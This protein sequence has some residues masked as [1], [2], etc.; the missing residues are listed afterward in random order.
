MKDSIIIAVCILFTYCQRCAIATAN[1]NIKR[2]NIITWC[3]VSNEEFYKCGNFS[4]AV[5]IDR[6]SFSPKLWLQVECLQAANKEDCMSKLNDE[7]ADITTL[8]AGDVFIG[9]RYFSLLP[10]M[11]ELYDNGRW[12]YYSVAVIKKNTLPD[13]RSL[14][15]LRNKK[16]CFASVGSVASWVIPLET[17]MIEGGLEVM[18]CN[19]HVKSA[20]KYFG[21]SCAVNSLIDKYNPIGDNS[22]KLCELCIGKIPGGRCTSADPYAGYEGA[23]RCLV[24]TGEIAFLKHTTVN[25]MISQTSDFVSVG[26]NDF[27]L[28]CRDGSRRPVT[29]YEKCNWGRVPSDAV[30]VSSVK[31]NNV[32]KIYQDFLLNAV[33]LYSSANVTNTSVNSFSPFTTPASHSQFRSNSSF[34]FFESAPKYGHKHNLFLQDRTK[35]LVSLEENKQTYTAYLGDTL[36]S[37][38]HI[39]HCPI[40]K[41]TLCVTSDSEYE[42]CIKMKIA[43]KSQLLKPEMFCYKARSH[44]HCMQAIK[45]RDADVAVFDAGDVYTAGSLY[46][47]IPFI[48]EVYNLGVPEYYVVAVAKEEDP[49]TEM[50][51][52][53][54]KYTCHPGVHTGGGWIIPMAYLIS[55]GWIR[56]YGCDSVRAAVEYFGKSCAPGA[57][58]SE[59]VSGKGYDNLCH[60]CHGTSYKYC[61]RDANEDYYGFTGA[62]RC[63]VEGG[64]HVAFLKH[65]TVYENTDGKRREWWARNTLS[66]DFQLLCSDGT[67]SALNNYQKCNIG[68]VKANAIVTRGGDLYNERELNAFINLFVYAQQFFGRK[69]DEE[70]SMFM[71]PSPYSD[72]IFQDATQQLRVIESTYRSYDKYL[73]SDFMRAKRIVDCR[74]SGSA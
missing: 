60:L 10:I 12:Y 42:K 44:I 26:L 24:E 59:Y 25:E 65:T 13:V 53:K 11:Q 18:D 58:S 64:G 28:L 16:A 39:R 41:M 69:N 7:Y 43:L 55:N 3:T 9:G 19:N 20:I 70:F 63:L 34:N 22:N 15:D 23:F 46:D 36:N 68:K 30:V 8:E 6:N 62:F 5:Q 57:A 61:Q 35:N 50:T 74:A 47:L 51:Y 73:G 40:E 48:S 1:L 49:S 27:E 2:N 56:K 33:K 21:P 29:E 38:L 14:Y 45:N 31:S 52:L 72:L 67:R 4:E 66:E 71:S 32:T 54:G 17:L 37:T